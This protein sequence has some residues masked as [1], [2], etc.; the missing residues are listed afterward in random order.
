MADWAA[1]GQLHDHKFV[2][3]PP[4]ERIAVQTPGDLLE[5]HKPLVS[6]WWDRAKHP[7]EQEPTAASNDL[8]CFGCPNKTIPG[9]ND[10]GR[11]DPVGSRPRRVDLRV[12]VLSEGK[13]LVPLPVGPCRCIDRDTEFLQLTVPIN[14]DARALLPWEKLYQNP[15]KNIVEFLGMFSMISDSS[16][17][18]HR[19]FSE[20]LEEIT[21]SH[22]T[23]E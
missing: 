2:E 12:P 10:F 1:L 7:V 19:L 22:D 15:H 3:K 9:P 8:L 6:S 16:Y 18:H 23:K 11:A 13:G 20:M 5:W 21:R 17:S 4:A 14:A